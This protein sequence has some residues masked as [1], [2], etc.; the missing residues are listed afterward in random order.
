MNEIR[1]E[2]KALKT[3]FLSAIIGTLCCTTPLV[4]ALIGLG[5]T[6][7]ALGAALTSLRPVF[8]VLAIVFA[9]GSLALYFKK[10]QG[11]C[12]LTTFKQN[13]QTVALTALVGVAL[14]FV[15]LY[16]FLP[17]VSP[18]VFYAP[19]KPT[20]GLSGLHKLDFEINGLS[21]ASCVADI[22][23]KLLVEDGVYRADLSL[24]RGEGIVV[25][26]PLR[27]TKERVLGLIGYPTTEVSDTPLTLT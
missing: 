25:Y 16:I 11:T 6:S 17:A 12:S 26:D 8:W 4:V 22:R 14:S 3:G 20:V 13:K 15:I 18:A 19:D 5:G 10:K 2:K 9:I 27:I 1:L 24:E 7:I 23:Q 21:C